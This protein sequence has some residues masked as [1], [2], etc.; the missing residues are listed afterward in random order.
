MKKIEVVL[1]SVGS[2]KKQ[3][4]PIGHLPLAVLS[5]ASWLREYG[6]SHCN[7]III[8]TQ[9][10]E[11]KASDVANADIVGISAMTGMQVELGL[12]VA[13]FARKLNPDVRIVWGGVHPSLTPEQTIEHPLVD[14]VVIGEG[15]N[16]FLE[17]VNAISS[18]QN[19]EGIPGTCVQNNANVVF[20]PP[21]AFI[22]LEK[23][24][25]PAYD[26]IDIS[27]Y[28]GI[29]KQ[30][31]YQSS[32]GCPFRCG[33]CY[34]TVF[35]GRRYRK[36]SSKKV[37]EE[38]LLI[39]D[40]YAVETF[41]FVDDEFF[42]NKKRVEKIL[43]GIIEKGGFGI[44][45]SC[46]LDIVQRFPAE[47]FKKMRKAGVS[48]IFFGA[49]SG[50]NRMLRKIQKDI[51]RKDIIEGS[52]IVAEAGIRPFL[53]FMSGFPGEDIEDFEQTLDMIVDLWKLNPL[54]TV[55]GIFPF[56]P[57]PGT[58]LFH[59]ACEAG[60]IPPDSLEGWGKWTF[61]YEPDNPWLSDKM[62]NWMEISF[63]IVRF[64]Y[65]L[66]RYQDRYPGSLRN[67][68]LKLLTVPFNVSANIRM[69]KR[70]FKYAWEWKLFAKIVRK[71]FGFL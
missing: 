55:N 28:S 53:S 34:N 6:Q 4:G 12:Q 21:R 18:N 20:G 8:D 54:I 68:V 30:F 70:W 59:K 38:L 24:P 25:L 14:C 23:L 29:E 16:T 44:S 37:I 41:A 7:I 52:R 11:I 27:K 35:C 40:T 42:I 60:L 62:K 64:K 65:Y 15:E 48:Q 3:F 63:Y 67:Y 1:V 46:R 45:A 66:I 26:L 22:D 71:T 69:R 10:Q 43:D 5:L 56:N 39:K 57:Y 13:T 17:I 61:Q 58:D 33:F 36:K 51:T 50:S 32:R 2:K 19:V 49:E 47:L 31:D 9:I